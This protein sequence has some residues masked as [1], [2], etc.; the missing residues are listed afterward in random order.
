MK[1]LTNHLKLDDPPTPRTLA[2]RGKWTKILVLNEHFSIY[3]QMDEKLIIW[4][5]FCMKGSSKI[6]EPIGIILHAFMLYYYY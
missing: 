6:I 2:P 1:N 5:I 3:I 4:I